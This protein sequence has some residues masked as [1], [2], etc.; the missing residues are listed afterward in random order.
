MSDQKK[1]E[2][3]I[4]VLGTPHRSGGELLFYCRKCN[5]HKPKLSCN[6]RKNAFK[7]W[8]CNFTGNNLGRLI[9][10]YGSYKQKQEW[11]RYDDKI[12]LSSISFAD[13]LFGEREADQTSISLPKEFVTLTG[14]HNPVSSIP[15]RYLYERG[16]NKED[17]LKWKIGY[18]PDG[19]YTGR[20]VIPSF[21]IEGKIN[22]FV[23]RSYRDDWMKY[24][25]PPAHKNEIIFNQLYIDWST[26]LVLT[27]GVFDAI[28]AGNAV[29]L[30]GS[31]LPETSKLFQEIAKHDTAIYVALDPDAEKKAKHLIKDMIQYGI[32]TYKV[33]VRGF[34]DVGSMTKAEFQERKAAALPMTQETLFRYQIQGIT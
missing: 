34:Q 19:E 20:V 2:I 4:D 13:T 8:V 3:L 24:K 9:K 33:D 18:C 14:K 25:N 16:I 22:Y 28:I 6:V 29:P 7:C 12:D 5:H 15:L 21:N 17:I 30:L 1:E 11:G 32:E 31:T 27:E 10:R 26:D 23:A